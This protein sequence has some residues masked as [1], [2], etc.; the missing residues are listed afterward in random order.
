MTTFRESPPRYYVLVAADVQFRPGVHGYL[1]TD[2]DGKPIAASESK[3][4]TVK[5][6]THGRNPRTA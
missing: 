2:K 5:G 1:E 4:D 6:L 3:T